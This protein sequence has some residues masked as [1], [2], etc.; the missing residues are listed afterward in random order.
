MKFEHLIAINDPGNPLLQPMT[1]AQLWRGLEYRVDNP[2]PFSPGLRASTLLERSSTQAKRLLD[3]GAVKLIDQ[4]GLRLGEAVDFVIAPGPEHPGG[5]LC[6]RIEEPLPEAL[7]L[8]FT[9]HTTLEQT[10][11]EDAA[12]VDYVKAAY[13]DADIEC[14]RTL[15]ELQAAGLLE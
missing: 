12:Y 2:L 1:R 7:F 3:F 15:R 14:V 10:H 13:R 6:I 9:Y 5:S 4:V 11:G 8:R